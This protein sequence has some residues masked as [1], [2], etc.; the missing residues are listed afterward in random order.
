MSAL[1]LSVTVVAWNRARELAGLLKNVED[2]AREIVVVDGGSQDDTEAVCRA[3]PLVRYLTRPWD[4]HFGRQKNASF[5]AARGEWILH[6]D[7]DERVGPKL[8]AALPKICSG[9]H[10]FY[11]VPMLWLVDESPPRYV[12][13]RK[14]YP[15]PVPRLFRNVPEHRYLEDVNPVHPSFPDPVVKT[16]K[17]LKGV[18]LLHYCLAWASRDE[19][20][21]KAADYAERQ[22]GSAETNA[23]YYLWWEGPHT[24]LPV[25][26]LA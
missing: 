23:S 25:G 24:V 3:H 20:V 6:L 21:A 8:A 14:H 22:P 10:S 16:M 1:D 13:T 19:L 2:F 11:R 26:G 9:K 12:R 17:K 4:G 5:E 18:F 15:C 7:T